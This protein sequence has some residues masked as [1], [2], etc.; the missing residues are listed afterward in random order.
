MTHLVTWLAA[1]FIIGGLAVVLWWRTRNV[2]IQ[3]G[4]AILYY[5]SLAGAWNV[6]SAR[7]WSDFGKGSNYLE[8]K[9]F[10]INLDEYY[11]ETLILYA[12]F[13]VAIEITLFY[14]LRSQRAARVPRKIMHST[15][16]AVT[17]F[18][19]LVSFLIIE[20]KISLA[21]DLGVSGYYVT[22]ASSN[23][24]SLHQIMNETCLTVLALGFAVYCS[25]PDARLLIGNHKRSILLGY[26][27]LITSAYMFN[28]LLGNRHEM[29]NAGIA[30]TLLYIANSR[31]PRWSL[32]AMVAVIGFFAL[33]FIDRYR[34]LPIAAVPSKLGSITTDE[35]MEVFMTPA[36]SSENFAAHCSM[37]GV[38]SYHIPP[39]FG[40]SFV[41]LGA[42][43]IP[44]FIWKERPEG[45]YPYYTANVQA[46]ENQGYTIHHAT[47][48]YLNFGLFGVVLGGV[49][50]AMVWAQCINAVT[51]GGGRRPYFVLRV[52]A[53]IL[54]VAYMPS[55]IRAGPEAYKSLLIEGIL[56]PALGMSF[57]QIRF[58]WNA[59]GGAPRSIRPSVL[60]ARM[61]VHART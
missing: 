41:S 15:V 21:L 1:T 36:F 42:S 24:F 55:V 25:G 32:L 45:V 5:W 10:P 14:S 33:A 50:L 30:G 53:P 54:F 46:M 37:Y 2:S 49:V 20:S 9:L 26:T 4:I 35:I 34:G 16:F 31:R 38:L 44:G 27:V 59:A 47:G 40:M 61:A 29:L 52:L 13:I 23:F 22:R 6:I 51:R 19:G 43:I 57:C 12:V 58:T 48:W 11:L 8:E 3:V 7:L 18:T 17:A 60:R 56:L 28:V 39:K